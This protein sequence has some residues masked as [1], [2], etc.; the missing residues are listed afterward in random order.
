MNV[1]VAGKFEKKDVVLD[2]CTK[3]QARGHSVAYDWTTH[4]PIKP[5]VENQALA[6]TYSE[7]EVS[8]IA[9]CD[10]FICLADEKGTTLM[11]EFGAALMHATLTGKPVVYAVGAFNDQS[12]WF[13]NALVRRKQTVEEAIEDIQCLS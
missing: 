8:G 3:L 5:Y 4:K 12:L 7:N 1:Y 10:V 6:K 11:M 9:R 13:F 2:V